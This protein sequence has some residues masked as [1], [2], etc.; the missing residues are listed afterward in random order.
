MMSVSSYINT[1]ETIVIDVK[2]KYQ[3]MKLSKKMVFSIKKKITLLFSI[4][5]AL[6]LFGWY[7]LSLFAIVYPA[8][9]F[10]W[11][12]C[13]LSSF[14]IF[15]C[16]SFLVSFFTSVL[17]KLGLKWSSQLCYNISLFLQDLW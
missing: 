15:F 10:S 5:L 4:E 9:Q 3:L 12:Y 7:Y 14:C 1:I 2:D 16:I 11:F 6:S 13:A 8:T 17:R